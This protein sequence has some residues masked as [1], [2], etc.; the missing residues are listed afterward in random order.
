M[1]YTCAIF[2]SIPTSNYAYTYTSDWAVFAH[3]VSDPCTYS[4]HYGNLQ[5]D[6][7]L[8]IYMFLTLLKLIFGFAED[9]NKHILCCYF[10]VNLILSC[11]YS[12]FMFLKC[13]LGLRL[14]MH[15]LS[16]LVWFGSCNHR[17]LTFLFSSKHFE[18]LLLLLWLLVF[19][20]WGS[21]GRDRSSVRRLVWLSYAASW[22][23]S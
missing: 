5:A 20:L 4:T 18:L 13:P 1:I 16:T 10:Y 9:R 17:N 12:F 22:A 11:T 19:S 8:I 14:T 15:K 23:S 7:F 3:D 21:L 2:V 6:N